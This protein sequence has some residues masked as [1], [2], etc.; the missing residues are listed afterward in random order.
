MFPKFKSIFVQGERTTVIDSSVEP[1]SYASCANSYKEVYVALG[2]EDLDIS[3]I[4]GTHA[5]RIGSATE[6]VKIQKL[7]YWI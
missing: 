3:S 1:F 2:L 7:V 5:P 6:A 4:S